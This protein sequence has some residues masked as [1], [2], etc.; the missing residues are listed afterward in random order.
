MNSTRPV[1]SASAEGPRRHTCSIFKTES[2]QF[3]AVVPHMLE[4]LRKND[5]YLY[6]SDRHEKADL[7]ERLMDAAPLSEET[8]ETRVSFYTSDEVYLRDGRFDKERVLRFL[9]DERDK[10]LKDGCSGLTATGEMSW[11]SRDM[12]GV[13]DLIEYEAR[14]NFMYPDSS[15]DFLCQYSETDFDTAILVKAVMAHPKVIV[16]G[17]VCGNPYYLPPETLI[18]YA[19]GVVTPDVLEHMEKDLF[20]RSVLSE[21]GLLEARELKRARLCLTML[22]EMV[23][24]DFRDRLSAVSFFN[25]LALGTCR[26]DDTAAHI[27]SADCKCAELS[28]RLEALRMFRSCMEAPTEWQS[29]EGVLQSAV[30]RSVNGSRRVKMDLSSYKI[31]ASSAADKAFAAFVLGAAERSQSGAQINVRARTSEFGL[32]VTIRADGAGVPEGAKESLFDQAG[33]CVCGRSL[34]LARELLESSGISVRE[35]GIPGRS[36]VFEIHVPVPRYRAE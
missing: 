14:I 6:I 25:E 13:R 28:E 23:L 30:D 5:R 22:D 27:R 4:G 29:L 8:I 12:P 34:C 7:L 36:T 26:D 9:S 19:S 10:A 24:N 21:I 17:T 20:S 33:P 11:A 3:A 31:F 1:A 2:D 16:R 15:A 35:V 32:T 18:S